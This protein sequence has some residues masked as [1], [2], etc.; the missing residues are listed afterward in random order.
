MEEQFLRRRFSAPG[1]DPADA[2]SSK[3]LGADVRTEKAVSD[4][5]PAPDRT[6]FRRTISRGFM[7]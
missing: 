3:I 1:V 7:M 6:P 2:V 4:H 5:S